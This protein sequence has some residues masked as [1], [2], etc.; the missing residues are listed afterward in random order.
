MPWQL[1]TP[2][3]KAWFDLSRNETGITRLW[4]L[5][6]MA[7]RNRVKWVLHN[8]YVLLHWNLAMHSPTS[9]RENPILSSRT[10]LPVTVT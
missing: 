4:F 8:R 1:P 10:S 9:S 3:H 5:H 2:A 7:R 6:E